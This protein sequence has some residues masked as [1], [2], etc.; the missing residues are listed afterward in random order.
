MQTIKKFAI[1]TIC[2]NIVKKFMTIALLLKKSMILLNG[3][4]V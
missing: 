2:K 3:A 4:K 1:L